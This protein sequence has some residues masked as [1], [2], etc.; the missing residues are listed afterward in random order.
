VR[1]HASYCSRPCFSDYGQ[2]LSPSSLSCEW[3]GSTSVMVGATVSSLIVPVL[4]HRSC[5]EGTHRTHEV[6]HD[7]HRAWVLMPAAHSNRSRSKP[8]KQPKTA[9]T[10]NRKTNCSGE[11]MMPSSPPTIFRRSHPYFYTSSMKKSRGFSPTSENTPST[12]FV[13][14]GN[15]LPNK[16]KLSCPTGWSPVK[17]ELQAIYISSYL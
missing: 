14:R 9:A 10:A 13:N 16:C 3:Y 4:T 11:I 5:K 2:P 7:V 8:T 12:H 15:P 17:L 6:G 1:G